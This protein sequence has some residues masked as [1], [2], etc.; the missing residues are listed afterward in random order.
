[1]TDLP[2]L[3]RGLAASATGVAPS[4]DARD[5][6]AAACAAARSFRQALELVWRL[7]P[8]P[9]PPLALQALSNPPSICP[10][11]RRVALP[12][13]TAAGCTEVLISQDLRRLGG[14][15]TFWATPAERSLVGQCL[16]ARRTAAVEGAG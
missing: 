2:R 7:R 1:M 11:L 5:D 16:R 10:V 14:V 13:G 9:G 6:L 4:Y 15:A 12:L 3:A 8:C